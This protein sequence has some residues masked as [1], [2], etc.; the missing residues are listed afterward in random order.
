MNKTTT[1]S[2]IMRN[3]V[4][5]SEIC[6]PTESWEMLFTHSTALPGVPRSSERQDNKLF[7]AT[8]KAKQ[9]VLTSRKSME[10]FKAFLDETF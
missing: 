10:R 4:E 7:C 8:F 6:K 9:V 2:K 3:N 5:Y 1:I